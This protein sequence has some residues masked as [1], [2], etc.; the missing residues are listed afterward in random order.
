MSKRKIEMLRRKKENWDLID[1]SPEFLASL[2]KEEADYLAK[3]LETHYE[4]KGSGRD[5]RKSDMMYS[6]PD[7]A[8]FAKRM[9]QP[10]YSPTDYSSEP[11]YS[12]DP[13]SF[14]I[15]TEE[16]N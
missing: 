16:E 5:S 15:A 14:L 3:F 1:Y 4:G 2:S 7:Y 13:E 10:R 8:E 9:N 12:I 6:E 11:S